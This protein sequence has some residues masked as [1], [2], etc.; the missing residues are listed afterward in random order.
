MVSDTIIV[1]PHNIGPGPRGEG[2]GSNSLG[3]GAAAESQLQ[4]VAFHIV[5]EGYVVNLD[6]VVSLYS[7]RNSCRRMAPLQKTRRKDTQ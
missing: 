5:T 7:A 6:C 2:V 4:D 1:L 3:R